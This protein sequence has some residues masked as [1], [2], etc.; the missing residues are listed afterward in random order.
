MKKTSSLFIMITFLFIFG[1]TP[2]FA[3]E[4]SSSPL[5]FIYKVINFAILIGLLYYFA[6]KPVGS[7]FKSS[8]ESTKQNLDEARKAQKEVEAELEEFR[9]KL[10]QMKQEAQT[11]VEN[12]RKEAES[13]KDRIISEGQELANRMKEQVRIAVEQEYKKAELEL[14]HW[15]A[16]ETV[17]LAEK[18][19]QEKINDS[20]HENLVKDYL[21][22]LH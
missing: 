9:G 7:G 3:A 14:R 19:I 1:A 6:K 12:A 11:M 5:D 4:G 8:A 22:Q 21:N 16:G 18:V 10:A 2:I 15:T 20:H 13:E 17:K